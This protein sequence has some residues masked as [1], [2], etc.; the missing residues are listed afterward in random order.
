MA[1]ITVTNS[2]IQW[3]DLVKLSPMVWATG[4]QVA[5]EEARQVMELFDEEQL[6]QFYRDYSYIARS[7]FS[8]KIDE[9]AD[10]PLLN[11]NQ[12][13]TMS[14]QV[15][16]RGKAFTI[17]E[18]L[19]DGNKYRDIRLGLEDLGGTLFRGLALDQTHQILTFAFSS[20]MTDRDGK[21]VNVGIAKGSSEAIYAATHTMT[22]GATFANLAT[23]ALNEPDLR[24]EEDLTVNF[25]DQNGIPIS[26]LTVSS[27]ILL[28]TTDRTNTHA[29]QR[30]VSP[31]QEWQQ[32]TANR[33]INVFKGMYRHVSAHYGATNATGTRDTTKIK[34]HAILDEKYL[35]DA[36]LYANF[37]KPTPRG[38][39]EDHHNGGMLWRSKAWYDIGILYAHIGV[40]NNSST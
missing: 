14:M 37:M 22:S 27:G 11:N 25:V 39:F 34:Y 7:G 33:N 20:T 21:T 28:T 2:T 31:L 8:N 23:S 40:G 16:K 24:A 9:A 10:Y 1:S 3:N 36:A 4:A 26:W 29:A 12:G 6:D 19:M 38:P 17:T 13:D 5:L 15:R 35:R 18:D 32:D 30:L